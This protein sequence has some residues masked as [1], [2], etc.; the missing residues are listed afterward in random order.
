MVVT[1]DIGTGKTT[2]CRALLEQIDRNDVHRAR[3]ESVPVG[4]G[5]AEA[6]PAGLRRD[7]ARGRQGAAGWRTSSKQELIETLYDFLL[8]LIPLQ[9][10]APC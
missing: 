5:S 7:L 10:A 2:L 8:S 1:G 4:R 9:G 6:D 3:A